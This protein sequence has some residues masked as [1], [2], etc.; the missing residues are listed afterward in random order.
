MKLEPIPSGEE[1]DYI[2]MATAID[3]QVDFGN[4]KPKPPEDEDPDE[5]NTPD[6]PDTEGPKP[7]KTKADFGG[8]AA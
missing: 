3:S 8:D 4:K 5:D 6:A 2:L 7:G 1:D